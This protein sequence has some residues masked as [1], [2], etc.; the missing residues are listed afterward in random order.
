MEM[1]RLR[2]RGR[3]TIQACPVGSG[4]RSILGGEEKQD[5]KQS[6]KRPV[7]SSSG[8]NRSNH[9]ACTIVGTLNAD[10]VLNNTVLSFQDESIKE[11]TP[12]KCEFK[13]F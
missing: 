9:Q 10:Y 12:S 1:G 13:G 2:S 6:Q 8:G 3:V 4:T 5:A 7:R 11:Y